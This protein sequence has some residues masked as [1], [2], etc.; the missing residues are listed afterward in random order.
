[1]LDYTE[2]N[3]DFSKFVFIGSAL[4]EFPL[5]YS[6]G[7]DPAIDPADK[8]SCVKTMRRYWHSPDNLLANCK[9]RQDKYCS[10]EFISLFPDAINI[11]TIAW[12]TLNWI[13][14]L[15]SNDAS[16]TSIRDI[17]NPEYMVIA[18]GRSEV[19]HMKHSDLLGQFK[20]LL[21]L[22]HEIFPSITIIVCSVLPS[23]HPGLAI[24]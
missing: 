8:A 14:F 9:T 23:F 2:F 11:A 10:S 12:T 15:S 21:E 13:E 24:F 17:A 3:E 4:L 20:Q 7:A 22:I 5:C 18:L 1:V 6:F 19:P 16:I